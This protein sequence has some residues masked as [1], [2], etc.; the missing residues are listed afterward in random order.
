[1]AV[2]VYVACVVYSG[3]NGDAAFAFMGS[4]THFDQKHNLDERQKTTTKAATKSHFAVVFTIA[5]VQ[6]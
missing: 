5:A 4:L 6:R 2:A 1:M 3:T